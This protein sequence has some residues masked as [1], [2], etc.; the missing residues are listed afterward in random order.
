MD[1]LLNQ[2]GL[3][4]T[5]FYELAILAGIFLILS[6][7]Y[8]KPFLKLFELRHKKTVEDRESAA[9]LA[10]QAEQK[11]E[12]YKS[13]LSAEKAA[14]K[15]DYEL[16]VAQAKKEEAKILA[17]ARAEAKKIT[18]EAVDSVSQQRDH[19]KA[20]L[21]ADLE[22]LAQEVSDRLLSRKA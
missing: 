1:A 18:Q 11:W 21:K 5:F 10:S 7:V 12:E 2:L 19:L 4:K 16:L 15:Q 6:Q 8:F 17:D 3:D 13:I 14:M 20:S 9:K 22:R